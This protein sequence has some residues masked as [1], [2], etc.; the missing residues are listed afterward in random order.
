MK[1]ALSAGHYPDR[2]GAYYKGISEYL[3]MSR[4]VLELL[5]TS[6]DFRMVPTG[7]LPEKVKY[8]NSGSF[9]AAVELHLNACG[10]CGAKGCETLY[11][12]GS[13]T[14]RAMA[15]WVQSVLPE[16]L[17]TRDRGAKEGWYRMDRPGV[18][19][20]YGDK[21]GDETPDYFLAK[22]AMPAIIMEPMFIEEAVD[23]GMDIYNYAEDIAAAII[24]A[25]A[26]SVK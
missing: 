12:P 8:I 20:Y 22:T 3:A 6:S 24:R 19:D 25:V 14:G 18:V 23:R 13:S 17:G 9:D 5:F 26:N 10:G 11:Y 4:L 7:T 2:Q 15:E 21:D 16:K 1:I